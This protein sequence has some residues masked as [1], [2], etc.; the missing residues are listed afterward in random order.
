VKH[1]GEPT[2][3]RLPND[4]G[5]AGVSALDRGDQALLVPGI[6]VVPGGELAPN[7]LE[8]LEHQLHMA[9]GAPPAG[10]EVM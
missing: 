6:E 8:A 7:G 2:I 9:P 5:L 10:R 4:L 1:G 3:P